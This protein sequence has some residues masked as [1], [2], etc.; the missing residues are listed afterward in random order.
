MKKVIYILSFLSILFPVIAL[1][2][3]PEISIF[4]ETVE[5]GF[6]IANL[7]IALLATVFAIKLAALSQGGTM[8]KTW[9]TIAIAVVFFALLEISGVLDLFGVIKVEGLADILEFGFLVFLTYGLYRTKKDLLQKVL[10][11]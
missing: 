9:N 10:G 5:S 11:R 4:P 1:A 6:E 3:T 7:I 2:A 8:E